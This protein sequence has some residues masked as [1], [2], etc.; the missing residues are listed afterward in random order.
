LAVP[1]TTEEAFLRE[2]DEE[3]RRDTLQGF[4]NRWGKKLIALL[5]AGLLLFGAWLWWQDRTTAKSGLEGE[6]LSLAMEELSSGNTDA[7]TKIFEKLKSSDVPGNRA[8]SQLAIAG[9]AYQKGDLK[10]AIAGYDLIA[11]DSKLDAPWRDVATIRKTAAQFDTIKPEEVI[12]RMKP[13]AV[14]GEPW[15]GSAGEMTAM[16]YLRTGKPDLAGKMFAEISKDE[17]VPESIRSRAVQMAG[18]LGVDAVN[19][20]TKEDKE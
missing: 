5:V 20:A 19:T 16:A 11:N 12:A 3:L 8:L 6:E 13:L 17:Q 10:A 1:P 18:T 14:S 15:F 7:A 4:W 9:L 2:V